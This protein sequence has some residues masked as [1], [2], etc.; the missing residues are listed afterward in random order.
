MSINLTS[1]IQKNPDINYTTVDNDII[2]MSPN[3]HGYY[4]LNTV[5][6]KIWD[7]IEANP[8]SLKSIVEILQSTY[9]I[10]KEQAFQDTNKF[11]ETMVSKNIFCVIS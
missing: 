7:L 11:I 9:K 5:G 6:V 2:I 3:D 1:T 4:R 10:S 8:L